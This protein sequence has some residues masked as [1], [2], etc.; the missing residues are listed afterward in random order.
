MG[1]QE[2]QGTKNIIDTAK[3]YRQNGVD[4]YSN[5][6]QLANDIQ[7]LCVEI[8]MDVEKFSVRN[9]QEAGQRTRVNGL[10]LESLLKLF[11]KRSLE[12]KK[13]SD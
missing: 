1:E 10:A 8:L 11:R 9:N 12:N 13:G 6:I 2:D 3:Y 5:M 7:K 4:P